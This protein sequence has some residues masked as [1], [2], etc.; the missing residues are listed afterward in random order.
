MHAG[1]VYAALAY[2]AWGLFPLFFKQ[3]VAVNAFEVVMHRTV[4]SLVFLLGVLAVRQHWAWLG[5]VW[6]T[7][8]VLGAFVLS[9]LLLAVNWCT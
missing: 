7:P 4:W 6:R 1:V 2:T 8:R 9:A 3:L 5:T